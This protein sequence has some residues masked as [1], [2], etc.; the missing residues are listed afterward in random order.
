LIPT[1]RAYLT[2]GFVGNVETATMEALGIMLSLGSAAATIGY[3]VGGFAADALGKRRVVVMSFIILAASCALFMVA[4]DMYFLYLASFIE[5]FAAGFSSPAISALVADCSE[6]SSRGMAYGVFNLSWISAGIAGPLLAGFMAQFVYLQMPFIVAALVGI[7]GLFLAFLLRGKNTEKKPKTEKNGGRVE[8]AVSKQDLTLRR[9]I[10]LFS[11]TNVLNGLLNGFV[12]PVLSGMLLFKLEAAPAEYGLVLSL[13]SSLVTGIVQLP[14]GKLTDRFGRKPL[15]LFGFL[16]V[17]LIL[18]LGFTSSLLDFSLIMGGISAVGNISS[19]AI[20]AWLMDL[21]PEHRRANISGIT[22]TLNGVGL[23]VG[24]NVGSYVWNSTKPDATVSCE[25]AALIFV[26]SLPFYLMLK[27]P[28]KT[29]SQ[30][31]NSR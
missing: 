21:I 12:N 10:L 18:L 5:F 4:P 19:P 29:S 9:V 17:P 23:T 3:F 14:G 25:I 1:P 24:P 27:E 8:A 13:A 28:K 15:C 11:I 30:T 7:V 20:S 16:G 31:D 26:A 22:Q 2:K 6:Q